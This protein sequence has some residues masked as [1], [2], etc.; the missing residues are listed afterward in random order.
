MT[1]DPKHLGA[2]F[3]AHTAA[4]FKT[5]DIEK[6]DLTALLARWGKPMDGAEKAASR[7]AA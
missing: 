7:G 3:D 5:R 6:Q 4:E 1:A 2:M